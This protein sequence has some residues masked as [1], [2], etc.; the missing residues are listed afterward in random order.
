MQVAATAEGH[1]RLGLSSTL[2]ALQSSSQLVVSG[3]CCRHTAPYGLC[4][5]AHGF[6]FVRHVRLWCS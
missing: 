4:F 6:V 2:Y 3:S 5:F 1:A